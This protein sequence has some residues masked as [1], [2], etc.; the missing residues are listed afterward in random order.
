MAAKTAFVVEGSNIRVSEDWVVADAVWRN[1]SGNWVSERE[2][3]GFWLFEQ[4]RS[5]KKT[6][7]QRVSHGKHLEYL[8]GKFCSGNRE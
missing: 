3:C 5:D 6:L 8:S 2:F 4:E 1:Q 7:C